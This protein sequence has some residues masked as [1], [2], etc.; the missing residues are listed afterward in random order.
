MHPAK[1]LELDS[2]S[3]TANKLHF[4]LPISVKWENHSYISDE[5]Y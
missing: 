4:F 3:K 2:G 5:I 1:V